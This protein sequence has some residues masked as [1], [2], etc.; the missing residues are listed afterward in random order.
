MLEFN[1][2]FRPRAKD[3]L[4]NKIFDPFR[5]KN[6]EAGSPEKIIINIDKDNTNIYKTEKEH[7]I[8]KEEN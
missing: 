1:P 2:Y 7:K 5:M 4:R 8:T 3:L 6:L